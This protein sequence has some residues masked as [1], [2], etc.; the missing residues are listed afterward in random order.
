MSQPTFIINDYHLVMTCSAC[1]EQYDVYKDGRQVAY[2]RLR[3]G[4]FTVTTPDVEG[5]CILDIDGIKS[6]GM[7]EDE[8]RWEFLTLAIQA[9]DLERRQ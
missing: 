7:F 9:I 6:D 1:P 5:Y 3:H 4:R 8:A 2:L